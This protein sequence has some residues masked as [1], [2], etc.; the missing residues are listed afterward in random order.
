MTSRCAVLPLL[1]AAAL[2]LALTTPVN[3]Q[4]VFEP[5]TTT[6]SPAGYA[7][8]LEDLDGDGHVDLVHAGDT[9]F[10]IAFGDG[11][12][13]F[14]PGTSL[15]RAISP[16]VI[17][18]VDEDGVRDIVHGSPVSVPELLAWSRGLGEGA[19]AAPSPMQLAS[20]VPSILR[21]GD[22]DGDGHVDFALYSSAGFAGTLRILRG[23][24][25]GAFTNAL[26]II[27]PFV[28]SMHFGDL[29]GD[30]FDDL[31]HMQ[32]G[33]TSTMW[34]SRSAGD[35]SFEVP[36]SIGSLV[37]STERILGVRELVGGPP[38]EIITSTTFNGGPEV[39]IRRLQG[40]SVVT[41][42]STGVTGLSGPPARH[43]VIADFDSDGRRDL[44]VTWSQ[45]VSFLSLAD[46]ASMTE[47][48]Y[49]STTLSTATAA[50][51]LNGDG[52]I[53]LASEQVFGGTNF[54][55]NHTYF[56]SEPFDDL[57]GTLP[58]LLSIP[59][60]LYDGAFGAGNT[61]QVRL[62][63]GPTFESAWLVGGGERIDMPFAGG[64][65]VPAPEIVKG[66]YP[67]SAAGEVTLQ[68]SDVPPLMMTDLYTQ[69]WIVDDSVP[70]GF[71][72]STAVQ[73]S[74]AR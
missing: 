67:I 40:S 69:W 32:G 43:V 17:V 1:S 36:V 16:F 15:P 4:V 49:T 58:S 35:G 22:M 72:A 13:S 44:A 30:G 70:G 8:E 6:P 54:S 61:L 7:I 10:E 63:N 62:V 18:D 12:G 14:G 68:A 31:L 52:R 24:G 11:S 5:L 19:F 41:V 23:D 25:R 48:G 74:A 9:F 55:L 39:R 64:V 26:Q 57:G 60:Q 2:V 45:W 71:S 37:L 28:V 34:M 47:I 59:V 20:E 56:E 73:I 33:G 50:G 65:L 66:P 42:T 21:A 29:D 53:D 27:A 51:D 38:D 3:S 46:D